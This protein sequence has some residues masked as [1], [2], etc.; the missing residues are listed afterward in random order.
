MSGVVEVPVAHTPAVP[1]RRST[2]AAVAVWFEWLAVLLAG[3]TALWGPLAQGSTFGW[4]RVG[5]TLLG[6]LTTA[7]L[8]VAL[9]VRGRLPARSGP[10]PM[11]VLALISWIW[12][13]VDWAPTRI[14]ALRSAGLWTGMLGAA[15]TV[16]LLARGRRMWLV[17]AALLVAGLGSLI[18]AFLQSRGVTVPGFTYNPGAGPSLLTGPYF[19]PS[20]FSGFLIVIS[21][22]LMGGMLFTRFHL[23]TP[24]LLAALVILHLIDF[25]TDSS[26]IPAVL[27]ASALPLLVWIWTRQRWVGAVLMALLLGGVLYGGMYFFTPQG[28]AR[29]EQVQGQLGLHNQ[30][31]PFLE[32]REGVWRYGR[33]M[34]RNH[35]WTGVGTGQFYTEAPSYRAA[36]RALGTGV[37][38]KAVNYAHSDVLQQGAELGIPGVVLYGLVLL[39]PLCRRGRSLPRLLWWSALP[40]LLFAGLYDAHL[41]AIPGTAM[42]ALTLA[43]LAA[44]PSRAR[45]WQETGHEGSST[46]S[47]GPQEVRP[48][49]RGHLHFKPRQELKT[50]TS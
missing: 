44:A 41:T 46:T 24:L 34:W 16:Q 7:V 5:L 35:P 28:Q 17:L 9:S 31:G 26:S 11:V 4:G 2:R 29:F 21:A 45:G 50:G 14:D 6:L 13:S 10:W 25:K 37:D 22:L 15:L 8:L 1:A 12:L 3:L 47:H 43:A 39:L 30:W 48:L 27:M 38:R 19:N 40:A 20:H 33:D 36:E 32:A 49:C 23:H 18:L 42:A